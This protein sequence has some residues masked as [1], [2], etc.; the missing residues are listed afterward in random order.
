[1][2]KELR[3]VCILAGGKGTRLGAHDRP[4][5]LVEVAGEPFL[6]HPLRLLRTY[7]ARRGVLCVDHLGEQ[8]ADAIGD[9]SVLGLDATVVFDAPGFSGTA[10]AVRGAL[11]HLGDE[12]LVLYG[13]TY[14]RID[15]RAMLAARRASG[16]PA[17]M[18]V[19]RN[20]GRWG[21]SNA[22]YADGLV[23]RHDKRAPDADMAWIDYGVGVLTPPAL[24]RAPDSGDLADVYRA[25]A[26]EGNLAGYVASERFYD[27]GSPAALAETEAFL[28]SR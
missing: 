13:D 26:A 17:L 4:K 14:L 19:L 25:L 20:A 10:G 7:G 2:I 1:V 27:I 16:R 8:I 5:P 15:Y 24:D 11:E 6:L 23:T 28:S 22:D 9:G 18:A 12:F 21:P 3:P